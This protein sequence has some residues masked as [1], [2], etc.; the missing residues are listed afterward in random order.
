MSAIRELSRRPHAGTAQE[1]AWPRDDRE[2]D[3]TLLE[4]HSVRE[5]KE[6]W[7][8]AKNVLHGALPLHFICLCMRPFVLMPSTVFREK[9]P[10]AS[11]E[12]F[13][14]FQE[15]SPLAGY[16][17]ARPGTTL[18]RM[19]DVIA[20]GDLVETEFY[21]RFMK[22]HGDRSFACLCFW[23]GGVFQ[24]MIGLHRTATQRDFAGVDLALLSRLYPHF[25]M[26]FQQILSLHRERAVRLSLEQLLVE[27]PIATVLL[28]WDLRVSYRNRSAVELSALWN[29]GPFRARVEKHT[30]DF[31]PPKAVLD[32]CASFKSEWNPSHHRECALVG[33]GGI[34]I[35]H[36][37]IPGLRAVV[38]LLQLDAAP[39]SMPLFLVRL[40]HRPASGEA[41][42]NGGA[43]AFPSMA[44]LSPRE[45][46]VARLVGQGCSNDEIASRLGKS[47]LT[48]KKQ[49][50]SV[51][52]KLELS[53]RGRL[54]A[55]LR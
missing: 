15:I 53:G 19:S 5:M 46:E 18:V 9:A 2:V 29:F 45:R 54:I 30:A 22:P 1:S 27:L 12:E 44:R 32:Y 14:L 11:E 6:F 55:L 25:D 31:T 8:A 41:G 42:G 26:V 20:D 38:N 17:A 39:L 24:G 36:D 43:D 10:F 33:P 4:L 28:D 48:V 50:H 23:H 51:Y 47:V 37:A 35:R 21:R 16:L 7:R 52:G 34:T 13:K 3:R 49:L 40:E